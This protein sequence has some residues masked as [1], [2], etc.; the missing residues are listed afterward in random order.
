MGTFLM[1]PRG[2]IIKEFQQGK[3]S[4]VTIGTPRRRTGTPPHKHA[5]SVVVLSLNRTHRHAEWPP[6]HETSTDPWSTAGKSLLNGYGEAFLPSCR[7]YP[8]WY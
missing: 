2:D 4:P 8:A 1:S 5:S 3:Q 6:L 7:I